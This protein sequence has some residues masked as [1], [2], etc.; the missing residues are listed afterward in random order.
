MEFL[1]YC[2]VAGFMIESV[3]GV[4]ICILGIIG[5]GGRRSI[6]RMRQVRMW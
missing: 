3:Q 1:K 2:G 6:C 4:K 5:I